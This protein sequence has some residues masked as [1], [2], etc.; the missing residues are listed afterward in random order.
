LGRTGA[1]QPDAVAISAPYHNEGTFVPQSKKVLIVDDED[2]LAE[3]LQAYFQRCGWDARIAGTGE[4][5][6]IAAMFDY[7]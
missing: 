4:S 3:N 5:A 2:Y 7:R 6:V 1:T